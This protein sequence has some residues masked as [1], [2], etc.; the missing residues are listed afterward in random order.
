MSSDPQDLFKDILPKLTNTIRAA[1][2]LAAQDVNFYKAVDHE[3]GEGIDEQ[4]KRLLEIS[5]DLLRSASSNP[6][7][8]SPILFGKDEIATESSWKPISNILDSIFDKIDLTYDQTRKKSPTGDGK[9]TEFQYLDEGNTS[10]KN[11]KSQRIQKPQLLFKIPVDNSEETP[12]KPK[13]ATK[14]NA[15]VPFKDSLVNPEPVYEDSVEIIDPPYYA[16][17]YE[18]EIANQPYPDRILT[19][20]EPI[21]PQDWSTTKATWVDSVDELNKMIAELKKLEEIA[22]DLEH[23]DYRTYY[24]I[25]CLMQISNREQDWIIDTLALRDDLAV[26]NEVFTDP[27][28]VKVF[29]GAFM[30]I[31]WLQ[32]DLGLYIVSLFDTYHASRALGLSRFSLAHLLEHY[33]HFK[34]SKKYQLADWRIRPL[35]S[36]MLAYARSDTHFLLYI[37]DQLKNKLIDSDKLRGVLHD[38]R[39][40]AKRRFEYTKFRPLANLFSKQVTCPVMAFNPKEPWGSIVSQYNVPPFKKPVVEILYNWRDAVA[41]KEDESVRFIMPNQL[42]V[43]LSMLESP[44]DSTKVLNTPHFVTDAVRTN[45]KEIAELIERTNKETEAGDW[46]QVDQWMKNQTLQQDEN[47]VD[48]VAGS[49]EIF[50]SLVEQSSLVFDNSVK[51][52]NKDSVAFTSIYNDRNPLYTL[53]FTDKKVIKHK[54][55]EVFA[56][57]MEI[58]WKRLNEDKGVVTVPIDGLEEQE[59]VLQ[60]EEEIEEIEAVPVEKPSTSK[61]SSGAILFND[62]RDINPNELITLRK[63]QVQNPRSSQTPSQQQPQDQLELD[64]ANADKIL[65]T[66]SKSRQDKQQKKK[67]S[68]DPYG[69][70]SEGPKPAKKAKTMTSGKSSTYK[71]KKKRG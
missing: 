60:Q 20:S 25:V 46:D 33:A 37:Y 4:G 63:R 22:V 59:V 40:V 34:T 53:E 13:I 39:Q 48:D 3:L 69:K 62:D 43:S 18:Y 24:G 51:L 30:D 67:R 26:L 32:R 41:R 56:S 38:S 36:P 1:S 65:L 8:F 31:I 6:S 61:K 15:L 11:E 9:D 54:V 49:L 58:A 19:K 27:N 42:L 68:F 71:S 29:H 7:E 50:E 55:N 5:N 70:D 66:D 23:H 14:P 12:F 64:Y 52:L 16:Q 35:S 17:P 57:R 47:L 28:I 21:P 10:I 44:V 45:A 2:S